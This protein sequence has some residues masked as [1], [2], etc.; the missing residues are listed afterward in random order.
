MSF[1]S[2][3]A[4]SFFFTIAFFVA[5]LTFIDWLIGETA[6]AELREKAGEAWLYV[7]D[8]G[9]YD[10]VFAGIEVMAKK[11]EK[12]FG[13]D[14]LSLKR[15]LSTGLFTFCYVFVSCIYKFIIYPKEV[16]IKYKPC[17]I[18]SECDSVSVSMNI[19]SEGVVLSFLKISPAMIATS[20]ITISITI[21]LLQKLY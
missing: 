8:H 4:D 18:F 12:V 13:P 20:F 14:F 3:F 7:G 17:G 6:R 19:P 2:N 1:F 21:Y 11:A 5:I 10:I 16:D 9:L 15:V